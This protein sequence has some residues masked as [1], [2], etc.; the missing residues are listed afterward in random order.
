MRAKRTVTPSRKKVT[1]SRKKTVNKKVAASSAPSPDNYAEVT[2]SLQAKLKTRAPV[3][4]E[5]GRD[6]M[7]RHVEETFK[8][9]PTRA[10]HIV[11]S[12][13][14]KGYV[15]FGPHPMFKHDQTV[16]RWTYHPQV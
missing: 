15:R 6:R 13:V 1:P 11:S 7:R 14:N 10:R 3:D 12:L 5:R 16:G 8:C 9:T 2:M 4:Y